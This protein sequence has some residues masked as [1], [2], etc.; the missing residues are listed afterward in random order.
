MKE[1]QKNDISQ[2][3]TTQTKLNDEKSKINN[4]TNY[5]NNNDLRSSLREFKEEKLEG[6][7]C[8]GIEEENKEEKESEYNYVR[9]VEKKASEITL[10]IS[11]KCNEENKRYEKEKNNKKRNILAYESSTPKTYHHSLRNRED[12]KIK[13]KL[14]LNNEE[15]EKKQ[16]QKHS[17]RNI[18]NM[19]NN[20]QMPESIHSDKFTNNKL[21]NKLRIEENKDMIKVQ[22]KM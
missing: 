21:L 11:Y 13:M 17:Q 9:I 12:S 10:N 22:I 18:Y 15:D 3:E 1:E 2:A 19:L 5:S 7:R 14:H 6:T 16:K 8:I 20:I 4:L